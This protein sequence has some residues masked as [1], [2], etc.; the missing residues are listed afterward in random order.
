MHC[1][2]RGA[3]VGFSCPV[4][5]AT[6]KRSARGAP[7]GLFATFPDDMLLL[8]ARRVPTAPA[9]TAITETCK[10]W[11]AA[12]SEKDELW[13]DIALARFPRLRSLTARLSVEQSWRELYR[14]QLFSPTPLL[15]A[16]Q[17]ADFV[18]TIELLW[19]DG[20]LAHE[21]SGTCTPEDGW[22]FQ[23]DDVRS[24]LWDEETP[25]PWLPAGLSTAHELDAADLLRD[26]GILSLRIA[27][28]VSRTVG[29]ALQTVKVAETPNGAEHDP[30]PPYLN[31]I[32][33]WTEADCRL[34]E[35]VAST[36]GPSF[37]P[38]LNLV[39]GELYWAF[40]DHNGRDLDE[41]LLASYFAHQVPWP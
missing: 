41:E 23:V 10:P 12:I 37:Q 30:N 14:S 16:P 39:E 26:N 2:V 1:F 24:N 7:D 22:S 8:V 4:R 3:H 25:P 18:V 32:I 29:R 6:T 13:H 20:R 34:Q 36:K 15:P 35:R 40:R 11:Y 38:C 17:L 19:P 31:S 5:M 9:R 27:A 28:Y 21:W 33:A